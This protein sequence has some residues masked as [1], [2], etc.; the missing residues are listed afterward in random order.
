M[1]VIF[2]LIAK[3]AQIAMIALSVKAAQVVYGAS[4]VIR[5]QDVF[6]A[7]TAKRALIARIVFLAAT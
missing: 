5:V 6:I 3:D 7:V 2:A 1:I 4:I